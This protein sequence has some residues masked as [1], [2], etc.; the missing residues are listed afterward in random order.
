MAKVRRCRWV[1]D[2]PLYQAYH[3]TEWG[4]P[5]RDARSL[6]ALLMLEGQQAGLSW[7]TVLKR[8][9]HYYAAFAQ[10]SPSE[11]AAF[12]L[13]D[14]ER[15]VRDPGLI[16][17]RKKI[18]AIIT[19]AQAYVSMCAEGIDF[20]EF[21]WGFVANEPVV[22]AWTRHA[23]VPTQTPQSVAMSRALKQHGFC[24]V[25]PTICYA[26]MQAAG[27]VNDHTRD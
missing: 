14:V 22:T 15:L 11:V 9:A 25:G 13:D 7:I 3:D 19:N 4:I 24:F 21:L 27:L 23:D 6:F 2:D 8:R 18:E 16:R 26:F 20:S 5:V 10:F 1:S 17:H 12:D